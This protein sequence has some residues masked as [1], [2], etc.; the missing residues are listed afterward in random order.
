LPSLQIAVLGD[1]RLTFDGKPLAEISSPKI[2]ALLA[3]LAV[4]SDRPHRR[5]NLAELLWPNKPAGA[6]SQNLR[7]SL[8]RLK[9]AMAALPGTAPALVAD[10][11]SLRLNPQAAVWLDAAQFTSLLEATRQHAHTRLESCRD[12]R[13]RLERAVQL[14]RGSFLQDVAIDSPAFDEWT[15]MQREWF[16]REALQALSK[17]VASLV[18]SADIER[19]YPYAWRQVEIDPWREI[20]HR[21]LMRVLALSGQRT[22]AMEQYNELCRILKKELDVAPA[23]ESTALFLE[24]KQNSLR[25]EHAKPKT[26]MTN[27]PVYHTAFIG[28]KVEL[29]QIAARLNDPG[30]RLLTLLGPGGAGKTRLAVQAAQENSAS[31]ADGAAYTPLAGLSSANW[32]AEAIAYA[33][34]GGANRPSQKAVGRERL[35]ALNERKMLLILDHYEHLLPSVE[36]IE[37]ILQAA[38]G[39]KLLVTSRQSLGLEAEWLLEIPGLAFPS[40]ELVPEMHTLDAVRLFGQAALRLAIK[41]TLSAETLPGVARICRMVQ[42]NPLALELAAAWLTSCSPSQIATQIATE[43]DTLAK[44]VAEAPERQRG[45]RAAFNQTWEKLS[46]SEKAALL[47]GSVFRGG[48]DRRAFRA[49]LAVDLTPE[50]GEVAEAQFDRLLD[51]L[52]EK[53]LLLEGGTG[54]FDLHP[55]VSEYV[56]ERLRTD[57][58][59]LQRAEARQAKFFTQ[60][61]QSLAEESP[62]EPGEAA[63]DLHADID[64]VRRAWAW[65]VAHPD[66]PGLVNGLEGLARF[67][68]LLGL[69]DEGE[70]AF[71]AAAAAMRP[72]AAVENPGGERQ[73]RLARLLMKLGHFQDMLGKSEA[74][75][76]A[77]Q[78]AEQ[79]GR[80]RGPGYP[81]EIKE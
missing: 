2:K 31:F 45:V 79:L 27:F 52:V 3:Y 60:R 9:Q 76:A 63:D 69:P 57:P 17:L 36:A 40:Q 62:Y 14:Y 70:M 68:T 71:Q 29:A 41:F 23:P 21:Q 30:C 78:E 10:R 19:A 74:A 59:D 11:S 58:S 6:A 33:V 20:A 7:Q 12:C 39:V 34:D 75:R 28:Y 54:R 65:G 35:R 42:G 53:A 4:H 32:V 50:N 56:A 13:E 80:T 8:R 25:R 67:Y 72:L 46:P 64:N 61:L 43:Q 48:F 81:E 24:I 16:R 1:F 26:S 66:G 37:Q 5:E 38:P 47:R 77:V 55:L 44:T 15:L 49:V 73:M 18:A 22:Q 51:G